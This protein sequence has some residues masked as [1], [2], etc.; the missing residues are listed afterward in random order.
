MQQTRSHGW[1]ADEVGGWGNGLFCRIDPSAMLAAA[2]ESD[3]RG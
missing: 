3:S 1:G 2:L